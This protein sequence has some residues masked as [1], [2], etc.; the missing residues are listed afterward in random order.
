MFLLLA[1]TPYQAL[2]DFDAGQIAVIEDSSGMIL[3]ANGI[4]SNL[5]YPGGLCVPQAG[6]AFYAA[7]PDN[8]DILVFITNKILQGTEKSGYP[9]RNDVQGIGID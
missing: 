3:P 7:H 2:A 9:V 1:V 8:Y 5:L 6:V 4:C